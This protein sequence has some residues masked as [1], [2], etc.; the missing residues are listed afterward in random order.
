MKQSLETGLVRFT[1]LLVSVYQVQGRGANTLKLKGTL[2]I[3]P[4]IFIRRQGLYSIQ[5]R[6][7]QV[8]LFRG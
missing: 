7:G 8:R 2:L 5:V 4:E 6:L 1:L 3:C